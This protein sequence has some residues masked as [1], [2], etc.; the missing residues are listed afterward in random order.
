M[1]VVIGVLRLRP[2]GAGTP[3][4]Q[5]TLQL[6]DVRRVHRNRELALQPAR[7]RAPPAIGTMAWPSTALDILLQVVLVRHQ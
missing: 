5:G 6:L 3:V 7:L 4:E 2:A 1:N